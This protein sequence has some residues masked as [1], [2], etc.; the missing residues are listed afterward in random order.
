MATELSEA[1]LQRLQEKVEEL[2]GAFIIEED[3]SSE[4]EGRRTG[5]RGRKGGRRGK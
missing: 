5:R 1:S 2:A 4:S 3:Q